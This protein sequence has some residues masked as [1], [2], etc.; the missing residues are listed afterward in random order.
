[1]PQIA[2]RGQV[3][4]PSAIYKTVTFVNFSC[5]APPSKLAKA[6]RIPFTEYTHCAIY[7]GS[8]NQGTSLHLRKGNPGHAC[9]KDNYG[10]DRRRNLPS[11]RSHRPFSRRSGRLITSCV[12]RSVSASVSKIPSSR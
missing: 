12:I 7:D 1:M 2:L 10:G 5:N 3:M 9:R 4:P 11:H 8:S 6:T